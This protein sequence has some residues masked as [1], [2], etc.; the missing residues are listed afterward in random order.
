MSAARM[1]SNNSQSPDAD[2]PFNNLK[3][4]VILRSADNVD[5]RVFKSILSL[6]SPIFDDMFALPQ[7]SGADNRN[8]MEDSLSVVQLAEDKKTHQEKPEM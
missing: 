6:S 1:P 2:A 7:V 4:D 3:A 8:E 5:F